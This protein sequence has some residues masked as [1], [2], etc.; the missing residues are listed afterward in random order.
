M[1]KRFFTERT[2]YWTNDF[3]TRTSLLNEQYYW[4]I[5]NWENESNRWKIITNFKNER[6]KFVFYTIKKTTEWI[7]HVHDR[8]T[9]TKWRKNAPIS[10]HLQ[11]CMIVRSLTG[12]MTC[13][14]NSHSDITRSWWGG[15]G[16]GLTSDI[17]CSWICSYSKRI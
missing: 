12:L 16:G 13:F 17:Y 2:I 8:W 10:R 9:I 15:E 7:V 5:F 14:R 1:N 6:N 3:T 11:Y 4:T